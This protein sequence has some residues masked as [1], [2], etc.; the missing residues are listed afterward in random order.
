MIIPSVRRVPIKPLEYAR[1]LQ[2]LL[3]K[4]PDID[5]KELA[6]RIDKTEDF[7]NNYLDLLK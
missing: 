4:N 1:M 7:I 5:I 2:H 3:D 6:K